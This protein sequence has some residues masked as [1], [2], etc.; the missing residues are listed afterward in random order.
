MHEKRNNLLMLKTILKVK[1]P[2]WLGVWYVVP[3][4]R[5][6]IS[7]DGEVVIEPDEMSVLT[8]L[9][10]HGGEVVSLDHLIATV[11]DGFEVGYN[12]LADTIIKLREHLGDDPKDP[13][14][15]ETVPQKGYRLRARVYFKDPSPPL[16]P[17]QPSM[18]SDRNIPPVSDE[19]FGRK[20]S[21]H[22]RLYTNLF[23]GGE[24][25]VFTVQNER[26]A[27][28]LLALV[29]VIAI[30]LYM[31]FG[32]SDPA[33]LPVSAANGQ[34]TNA[35][36]IAATNAPA[37]SSIPPARPVPGFSSPP[38]ELAEKTSTS[39]PINKDRVGPEFIAAT[40]T[41][42]KSATDS[43]SETR[44]AK[45]KHESLS[46]HSAHKPRVVV[47]AFNNLSGDR[48]QQ[49]LGQGISVSLSSE[50]S[51]FSG[52]SVISYR[53][54]GRNSDRNTTRSNNRSNDQPE[55][56][57]K[58]IRQL[59]ASFMIQGEI[60]RDRDNLQV[61]VRLMDIV[62]A[63]KIW[64][65]RYNRTTQ[66]IFQIQADIRQQVLDALAVDMTNEEK[67]YGSLSTTVNFAAYDYYLQGQFLLGNGESAIDNNKARAKMEK[68]IALDPGFLQAH[69]SLAIIHADNYRYGWNDMGASAKLALASAERALSLDQSSALANWCLGYVYL[70]VQGNH[71]R[72]IEM[73]ER[74]IDL[75]PNNVA[76][77]TLLSDAHAFGGSPEKARLLLE[78]VKQDKQE[79]RSNVPSTLGLANLLLGNYQ[80][81]LQSLNESLSLDYSYVQGNV[82]KLIALYRMGDLSD[83][84]TQARQL[85]S[86][87]P[88]FDAKAWA[89]RQPFK[90]KHIQQGIMNDLEKVIRL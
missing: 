45:A 59:G 57:E 67:A 44:S 73:S 74:T 61:M 32:K 72:A 78:S 87:H 53:N 77:Y 54:I 13:Q 41:A 68:A 84:Q 18:A 52:L 28:Y 62:N 20:R 21:S 83:A 86:L 69:I 23:G 46:Q 85:L 26:N 82:Y 22:S 29:V 65:E 12:V 71:R 40:K 34:H 10:H 50:L 55:D 30:A 27:Y 58:Q 33:P 39:N 56:V 25:D 90:D 36:R 42:L 15:I 64:E 3:T 17:Q 43:E 24:S 11:W 5:Q 9:V 76:G 38:R 60:Q 75:E 35:S 2:F 47:L 48:N 1:R 7:E 66:D 63:K 19:L 81:S 16:N 6:M 14:Y 8:M 89:D 88:G 79:Y 80:A 37:I 49:Y 51:R 70:Y 31:V 4:T